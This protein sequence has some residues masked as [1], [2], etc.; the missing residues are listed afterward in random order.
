MSAQ[1]L[2]YIKDAEAGISMGKKMCWLIL[3]TGFY[4]HWT[5]VSVRYFFAKTVSYR[6]VKEGN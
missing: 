5:F 4:L 1:R 3:N 6:M 2:E